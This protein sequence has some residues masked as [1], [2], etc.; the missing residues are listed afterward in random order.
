MNDD[1]RVRLESLNL[2]DATANVTFS[3]NAI[4]QDGVERR[5]AGISVEERATGTTPNLN[6]IVNEAKTV[7]AFK[8]RE[9]LAALRDELPRDVQARV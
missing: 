3:L 2:V 5:I 8:L 6:L 4:S 1:L 9:A 7:L